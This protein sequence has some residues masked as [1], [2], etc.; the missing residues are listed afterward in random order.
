MTH[1]D[2][3]TVR[4]GDIVAIQ[5]A[6]T[7]AKARVVMLG[8]SREHLGIDEE[9]IKWADSERLLSPTN[10]IIEWIGQNPLAHDDPK[11][12]P[13]GDYMFTELDDCVRCDA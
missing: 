9:F 10:A 3:S 12:A 6:D 7:V 4:L 8:D 11:Y 13:V 2:G 5:M 1:S